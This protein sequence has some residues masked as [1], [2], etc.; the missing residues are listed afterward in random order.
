LIICQRNVNSGRAVAA[1]DAATF[2]STGRLQSAASP[3]RRIDA[4]D[5]FAE[6]LVGH[7][8][9]LRQPAPAHGTDLGR[10]RAFADAAGVD[11]LAT[12]D[13]DLLRDFR[14]R[15]PVVA[16]VRSRCPAWESVGGG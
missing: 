16:A 2:A 3:A 15:W 6:L 13:R 5:H 11:Q 10:F 12:V 4:E 14:W 8:A 1:R 7:L 9:D